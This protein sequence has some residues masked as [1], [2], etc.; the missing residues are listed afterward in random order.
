MAK[1]KPVPGMITDPQKA[2]AYMLQ[3]NTNIITFQSAKSGE[4]RTFRIK[5]MDKTAVAEKGIKDQRF[6]VS[7]LNGPENTRDYKYLGQILNGEFTLTKKS[8]ET[9]ITE[10]T[11]SF[12]I[13]KAAFDTLKVCKKIPS[14]LSVF[15]SGRC[16]KCHK[17][18]TVPQSVAD[19]FGPECVNSVYATS[20]CP[21]PDVKPISVTGQ[22]AKQ[23]VFTTADGGSFLDRP[24]SGRTMY[25]TGQKINGRAA[26]QLVYG[27]PAKQSA[28]K[29]ALEQSL[30]SATFV[31][32]GH[33]VTREQDAQINQ[34]ID[35]YKSEGPE[36]YY[37]DGEITEE[38]AFKVA[39]NMFYHQIVGRA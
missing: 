20:P 11:P 33:E 2:L 17:A 24:V 19:G 21:V 1:S 27:R 34:M 25:R 15:H 3:P 14:L 16:G 37:H 26:A 5:P 35:Q 18:L 13:F 7:F 38:E 4:R 29:A 9:G 28:L 30:K 8:R 12:V 39:Y 10:Q 36:N 32:C 23:K 31:V 6:F 22:P